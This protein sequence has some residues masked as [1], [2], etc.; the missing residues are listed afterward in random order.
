MGWC[1]QSG[2]GSAAALA[3]VLLSVLLLLL[4][5]SGSAA[6]A[7]EADSAVCDALLQTKA[8][9]RI[10]NRYFVHA[11]L[12]H[13][14]QQG[15]ATI[16]ADDPDYQAQLKQGDES[17]RGSL[18]DDRIGPV[19]RSWLRRL[20]VDYPDYGTADKIPEAVMRSALHY[21]EISH[22]HPDWKTTLTGPAFA[23]WI[24]TAADADQTKLRQLRRSGAAPVVTGLLDEFA[25]TRPESSGPMRTAVDTRCERLLETGLQTRDPGLS[26]SSTSIGKKIQQGLQAVFAGNPEYDSVRSG[27]DL[28]FDGRVGQR[29][30]KWMV[31][32]CQDFPAAGPPDNF[33]DNV[34]NSLIHYAEI[35]EVHPDWREIVTHPDFNQWI[36]LPLPKEERGKRQLR[37]SGSAPVV[38]RLI[39][40]FLDGEVPVDDGDDPSDECIEAAPLGASVYYRLSEQD[41]QRLQD[42]EAFVAQV[43]KLVGKKFDTEEQLGDAIG[44]TAERLQDRCVKQQFLKALQRGNRNPA[45][46][47]RLTGES[48]DRIIN[49]LTLPDQTG[50]EGD[51][52]FAANLISALE[53][54]QDKGFPSKRSLAQFIRFKAKLALAGDA[55]SPAEGES[56]PP[57]VKG[58]GAAPPVEESDA[59]DPAARSEA[60]PDEEQ[61]EGGESEAQKA[62]EKRPEQT[63]FKGFVFEGEKLDRERRKQEQPVKEAQ[64]EEKPKQEVAATAPIVSTAAPPQERAKAKV[65]IDA[66]VKQVVALAERRLWSFEITGEALDALKEDKLFVPFPESDLAAIGRLLDVAYVNAELYATAVRSLLGS[67]AGSEERVTAIVRQ[68]RK[69]G[70]TGARLAVTATEGCQCSRRWDM[71]GRNHFTVYGFYPSW[72][73][74]SGTETMA[75]GVGEALTPQTGKA[76]SAQEH[77]VPLDFGTYSRIGYFALELDEEGKILDRKQWSAERGAKKFIRLAHK[78][79]SKVDLVIEARHWQNWDQKAQRQAVAEIWG[80]LDPGSQDARGGLIPD[81]VT[82]YFPGF[83]QSAPEKHQRIVELLTQLYGK[84]EPA[85]EGQHNT[86]FGYL[87]KRLSGREVS[88]SLNILIGADTLDLNPLEPEK[89]LLG[90]LKFLGDLKEILV[91]D[92]QIVDL[93]LVLL[94]QPV[95]DV[96]KKLRLTVENEFQGEERIDV[97]RRIVPVIPPNGH[98]EHDGPAISAKWGSSDDP[99]RQLHHDLFYFRDNFR[100][101]AFWPA[102][103]ATADAQGTLQMELLNERLIRVFSQSGE[104]GE[105]GWISELLGQDPCVFVCP[106]RWYLKVL[107]FVLLGGLVLFAVLTFWSCRLR[108]LVVNNLLPVL[109]FVALLILMFVAFIT[110]VPTWQDLQSTILG[111]L[112]VILIG[113][114]VFYY[115]R[116]VKQGPLP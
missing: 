84:I 96:K 83:V 79:L 81:G 47:Y 28:L 75:A 18:D 3:G 53:Q 76:S 97:L 14:V 19:T 73:S 98:K 25:G 11:D 104:Q 92:R 103:P 26:L 61:P 23:A 32:F 71:V 70:D 116:K 50:Q 1:I 9:N 4:L 113:S 6:L 41:L 59:P 99:Y 91:G 74:A 67:G 69:L 60:K 12:G 65:D 42:R 10:P 106:N 95:V 52:R 31:R 93:V 112:L 58:E 68:A 24:E 87:G 100:G 63:R 15:L 80:L 72:L 85:G 13:E 20:C 37:L 49:Q 35:A 77:G 43:A 102:V 86:L 44:P 36:V 2:T 115:I 66:L 29:T 108:T 21:A 101:V 88:P 55:A 109:V 56:T 46:E 40:Q 62:E 54:L 8:Q 78:Y 82:I 114:W 48:L 5:L 16:F 22:R 17:K 34:V 107:F 110:C 33:P 39:A 64:V 89:R 90:N 30:R 51:I 38:N 27:T 94:G 45:S 57:A 111:A 105:G 7:T